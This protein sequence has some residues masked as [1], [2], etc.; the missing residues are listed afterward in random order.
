MGDYQ[1]RDTII[2]A[3]K[4]E[5][6]KVLENLPENT[7][8]EPM[9]MTIWEDEKFLLSDHYLVTL[10]L[11]MKAKVYRMMKPTDSLRAKIVGSR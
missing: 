11:K 6:S 8:Y 3:E 7:L 1:D 10:K 5:E 4:S 9:S 2:E